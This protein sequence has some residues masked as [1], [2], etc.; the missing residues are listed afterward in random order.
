MKIE[1]LELP[2]QSNKKAHGI[3][4]SISAFLRLLLIEIFQV[5]I[6]QKK[7]KNALLYVFF[8]ID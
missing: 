4:A 3:T 5:S 6:L 2:L 7:S 1:V 8:I